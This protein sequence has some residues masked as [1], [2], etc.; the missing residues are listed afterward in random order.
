MDWANIITGV[1]AALA[2]AIG[3]PL[4]LRKRKKE[5]YQRREQLFITSKQ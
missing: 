2:V 1:L 5:G 3:L 4:A